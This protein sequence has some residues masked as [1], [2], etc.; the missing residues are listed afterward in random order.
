MELGHLHKDSPKTQERK[1]PQGKNHRFFCLET[2][3]KCIFPID[4]HNQGISPQ[5]RAFFSNFWKRAGE[6]SP[7]LPSSYAPVNGGLIRWIHIFD[8][9]TF[10]L[11]CKHLSLYV[12]FFM[13]LCRIC[14]NKCIASNKRDTPISAT[15][16]TLRSE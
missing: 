15:S 5:I 1:A 11:L 9:N 7:L 14:S 3:N 12:N 2:L 13:S 4:D 16:L 8:Y 6:T 10:L